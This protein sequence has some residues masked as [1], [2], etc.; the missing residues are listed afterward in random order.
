M[1]TIIELNLKG[2]KSQGE[3]LEFSLIQ[4]LLSFSEVF[5][6]WYISKFTSS[7]HCWQSLNLVCCWATS[8][9]NMIQYNI[10]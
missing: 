6:N 5:V 1:V 10:I 2:S 4:M 7:K 3:R 8:Y 9:H